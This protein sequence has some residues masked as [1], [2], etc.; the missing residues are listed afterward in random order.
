MHEITDEQLDK[1]IQG[2][3]QKVTEENRKSMREMINR[4]KDVLK[5]TKM[6]GSL[7]EAHVKISS[8]ELNKNDFK[9]ALPEG[10]VLKESLFG[11]MFSRTNGIS[12]RLAGTDQ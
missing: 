3:G 7:T 8:P 5:T 9:F 11:G 12:N 1:A 2:M 10:T 6:K 4:S